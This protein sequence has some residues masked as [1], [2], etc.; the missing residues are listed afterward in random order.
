MRKIKILALLIL[1]L[2]TAPSSAKAASPSLEI[3]V[4]IASAA[5]GSAVDSL[6]NSAE[7]TEIKSETKSVWK[8]EKFIEKVDINGKM[9]TVAEGVLEK[10]GAVVAFVTKVNDKIKMVYLEKKLSEDMKEYEE[11]LSMTEKDKKQYIIAFFKDYG[12]VALDS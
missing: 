3:L 11:Y 7:D 9:V 6:T 12:R 2:V 1:V 4:E 5:I 8:Q 10:T